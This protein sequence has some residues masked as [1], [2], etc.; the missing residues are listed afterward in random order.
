MRKTYSDI[1]KARSEKVDQASI[2]QIMRAYR[3]D[4][5]Q[6]SCTGSGFQRKEPDR[7]LDDAATHRGDSA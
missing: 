6:R 7:R 3:E 2:D 5:I 4:R 1:V